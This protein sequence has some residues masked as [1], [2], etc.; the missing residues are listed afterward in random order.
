VITTV[1]RLS[2]L[3]LLAARNDQP[4]VI[5]EVLTSMKRHG[6]P[7]DDLAKVTDLLPGVSFEGWTDHLPLHVDGRYAEAERLSRPPLPWP[8]EPCGSPTC[9]QRKRSGSPASWVEQRASRSQ[10]VNE[11]A[12]DFG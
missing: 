7:Q 11:S 8:Q 5:V 1:S 10:Y 3:Q 12:P 9:L 6:I 4:R 2:D